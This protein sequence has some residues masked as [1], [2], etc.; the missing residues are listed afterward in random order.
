MIFTCAAGQLCKK[1]HY[2]FE[3]DLCCAACDG[4]LH[5]YSSCSRSRGTI[6]TTDRF[7]EGDAD[8]QICTACIQKAE[9]EDRAAKT[10]ALTPEEQLKHSTDEQ[11]G[12]LEVINLF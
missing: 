7:D 10:K 8:D 4:K 1:S 3:E 9:K 12:C 5:G 6:D 11:A 2:P